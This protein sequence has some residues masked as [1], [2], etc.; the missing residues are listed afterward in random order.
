MNILIIED[1]PI[2]MNSIKEYLKSYSDE[3][4]IDIQYSY[5]SG[6]LAI[7]KNAYDLIL[8]DMQLPN[9]DIKSGEDGYKLRPL[10]GRDILREIKRKKLKAKIIVIT[11]FD[12]FGE[13]GNFSSLNDWHNYFSKEFDGIYLF[14]VFYNPSSDSWKNKLKKVLPIQRQ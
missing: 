3:I 1:D 13:D 10:A 7:L 11:Q 8:L 4:S 14:T 12:T 9:F 2:K 5:Q 6:L